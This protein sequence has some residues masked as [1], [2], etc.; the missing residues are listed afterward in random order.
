MYEVA[1]G[2]GAILGRAGLF[3]SGGVAAEDKAADLS[4]PGGA[5]KVVEQVAVVTAEEAEEAAAQEAENVA[6]AEARAAEFAARVER[7]AAAAVARPG[8]EAA[9]E[10]A[11]IEAREGRRQTAVTLGVG[12]VLLV[13]VGGAGFFGYRWWKARQAMRDEVTP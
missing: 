9:A 4:Q 1:D 13:A 8:Y 6:R 11:A 2:M 5:E 7:R 3:G 10:Q 12:A